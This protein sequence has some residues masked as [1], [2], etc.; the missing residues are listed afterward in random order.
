M[1]PKFTNRRMLGSASIFCAVIFLC[2]TGVFCIDFL[3]TGNIHQPGG[4][5]WLYIYILFF[6]LSIL[7]AYIKKQIPKKMHDE[8]IESKKA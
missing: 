6:I 3:L 1:R 5:K 4:N 7:F 2:M 8:E